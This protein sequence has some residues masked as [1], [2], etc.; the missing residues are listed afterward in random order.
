MPIFMYISSQ[1][2][3]NKKILL[4]AFYLFLFPIVFLAVGKCVF[5]FL[6]PVQFDRGK[7]K[8]PG[9]ILANDQNGKYRSESRAATSTLIS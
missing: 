3:L 5:R 4:I 9:D 1:N 8:R 6:K 2:S 7:I